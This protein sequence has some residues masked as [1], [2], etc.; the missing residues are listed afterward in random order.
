MQNDQDP[1]YQEKRAI[2]LREVAALADEFRLALPE[3]IG[4]LKTLWANVKADIL[5]AQENDTSLDLFYRKAHEITGASGLFNIKDVHNICAEIENI[6]LKNKGKIQ[7]DKISQSHIEE[8]MQSLD[9]FIS[10]S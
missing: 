2:M 5:E 10:N 7:D 9:K 6:A 8:L 4:D 3:M 1:S